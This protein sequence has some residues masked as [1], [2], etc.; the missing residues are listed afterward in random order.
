VVAL[1]RVAGWISL[2]LL[3]W[4]ARLA[5]NG[6]DHRADLLRLAES[7]VLAWVLIRLSSTLVVDERLARAQRDLTLRNPEALARA[8]AGAQRSTEKATTLSSRADQRN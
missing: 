6:M 8:V 1:V 3:L 2:L 7:L 5:F 4:F